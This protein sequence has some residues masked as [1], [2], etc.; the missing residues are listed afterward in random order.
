MTVPDGSQPPAEQS[1]RWAPGLLRAVSVATVLAVALEIAFVI[2]P[3]FRELV[4]ADAV[5]ALLIAKSAIVSRTVIPTQWYWNNGDV[6]LFAAPLAS[7]PLVALGVSMGA[8]R[9]FAAL[10]LSLELAVLYGLFR[11]LTPRALVAALASAATLLCISQVQLWFIY[12]DL[13]YGFLLTT[14]LLVSVAFARLLPNGTKEITLDRR[15]LVAAIALLLVSSSNPMRF[16]AFGLAPLAAALSWPWR[17]FGW[18]SRL[19]LAGPILGAFVLSIVI[20][21]GIFPRFLTFA[22]YRP[23]VLFASGGMT[24]V[25]ENVAMIGRGV[26]L[27]AGGSGSIVEALPG[28]LFLGGTFAIVAKHVA[29]SRELSPTRFVAIGLFAM[30]GVVGA[31]LVLGNVMFNPL[32]IR[33]LTP[34]V[35]PMFGLAV[36]LVL[37]R[38]P[39]WARLAWLVLLPVLGVLGFVRSLAAPFDRESPPWASRAEQEELASELR[40]RGLERGFT[41]YW[42]ANMLT[43]LT[44]DRVDVCPVVVGDDSVV[45]Y[46]WGVDATCFDRARF[47][48]EVFFAAAPSEREAFR[49]ALDRA[50]GIPRERVLSRGGFEIS[51]YATDEMATGW[52]DLPLPRGS[53]IRYPLKLAAT[54]LVF[55]LDRAETT[56]SGALATG[57]DGLLLHG[58]FIDMARGTYVATWTGARVDGPGRVVFE[59]YVQGR[60]LATAAL[61]ANSVATEGV[62]A[63]LPFTLETDTNGVELL[64]RS[65]AAGKILLR[66]VTLTRQ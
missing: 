25:R 63:T 2:G 42:H 60:V 18:R 49:K 37:E 5:C 44:E 46:R 30:F 61:D 55:H 28:L 34:A 59:V 16:V 43:L 52:L 13:G 27:L 39:S 6:W 29:L 62:I 14:Y 33:Y 1:P 31:S 7:L 23:P 8:M 11:Q 50:F 47:P 19:R 51:V 20:A 53:A 21:R 3:R 35:L 10:L 54:S 26:L 17:G 36:V 32:S 40:S 56:T 4:H 24:Q 58:P 41:S 66:D 38:P 9:V 64:V 45:P 48:K 22:P 57:E 12:V 65:E 15:V